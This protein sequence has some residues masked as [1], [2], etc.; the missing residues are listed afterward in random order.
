MLN[1]LFSTIYSNV[2]ANIQDTSSAMQTIIKTYCNN[3]YF[4]IL[5]R[6]NWNSVN[7]S[8]QISVT[9]GTRDYILPNDFGK[10]LY[11]HDSTNNKNIPFISLVK[12]VED[13]TDTISSSGNVGRYTIFQDVVR[14]QPSSASTLSLVSSSASDTNQS[15]RIKGTD[16]NDV[17]I[18]ETVALNGTTTA[19]SSNSFKEIR[20]ISKTASTTGRITI[21]SNSGAVTNA[22]L[23]PA[24][25][26]YKLTKIRLHYNPS[27][28]L[29][30]NVPYYRR[31]YPLSNDNDTPIIP[32]AD[33]I[34]LGAIAQAWRYKRQFAKAQEFERLFEKW[35]VDVAWDQE[36]QPN[37]THQ[38]NPKPYSRDDY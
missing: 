32:C 37:Q 10:E 2:G 31:P 5:R 22:I 15:V 17:E 13:F 25:L 9:A 8:Y 21:T 38:F 30:L 4:E 29:T 12:L 14:A 33:G 1:R 20:S 34:E 16:S 3:S 7:I 23:S 36:N 19:T 28:S 18:D 26:D 6:L 24:D 11:V 27:N 35:I